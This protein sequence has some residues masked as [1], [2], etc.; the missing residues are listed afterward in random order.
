MSQ[1]IKAEIVEKYEAAKDVF[2]LTLRSEGLSSGAAKAAG[3]H[4]DVYL[5]SGI[6]RQY[7]LTGLKRDEPAMLTIAVLREAQGRGGSV[8]LCDKINVGDTLQISLPRNT[9]ALDTSQDD[10]RLLAGGIGLTP[11]IHMATELQELRRDF[12]LDICARSVENLPFRTFLDSAPFADR[13]V[14][15]F[16]DGAVSSRLDLPSYIASIPPRAQLYACGPNR[17]IQEIE[18]LTAEWNIERVRTERFRNEQGPVSSSEDGEFTVQL[19]RS[20]LTLLV[21]PGQTLLDVL[22]CAGIMT[23]SSCLEGVC[24]TCITDVISGDIVHRDVCLYDEEKRA[25]SAIAPC[26][27]RAKP[28][29]TLVLDL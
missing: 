17:M 7:S 14:Y 11:I 21:P 15:H 24:G 13:I 16:S 3:A 27:S 25:N 10:Y 4:I 2:A 18:K 19:A 1:I 28:G 26:V 29:T 22:N 20:G 23:A 8:E 6:V 9:F 12:R 5:P